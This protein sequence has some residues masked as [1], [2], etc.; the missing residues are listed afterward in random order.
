MAAL[1]SNR[2]YSLIGGR[3]GVLLVK[4][5]QHD[6]LSCADSPGHRQDR[7]I[8]RL[9]RQQLLHNNLLSCWLVLERIFHRCS[10]RS[11]LVSSLAAKGCLAQPVGL[12][13]GQWSAPLAVE[14]LGVLT[15]VRGGVDPTP[16]SPTC[17]PGTWRNSRS[18]SRPPQ[19]HIP[20][21]VLGGSGASPANAGGSRRAP[22]AD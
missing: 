5:G 10:A 15:T 6:V 12:P 21:W 1:T 18:A 2:R 19:A 11:R 9:K 22:L 16:Q 3:V 7:S 14:R 13:W 8:R 17:R 4:V 20:A